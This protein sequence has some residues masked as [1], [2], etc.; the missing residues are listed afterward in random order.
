[1]VFSVPG[2][3]WKDLEA[4]E[5]ANLRALLDESA[6]ANVATRVTS[7][8]SE[9]GEAY[10]TLGTGTRA[11]AP[12]EVAG[13]SF[14]AD[15]LFGPTTAGEEWVRQHGRSTDAEVVSL[16]WTLIEDANEGAEF[17]G[18]IGALGD[19]LDARGRGPRG[20]R[21]RRRRRPAGARGAH[22]P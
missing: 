17:G 21:E 11:V 10:L 19:A 18:T 5:L 15:E 7:V 2:L 12:R 20:G 8:V 4:P 14:Q 16:G 22:P 13:M 6:I 9:P 3:T 1:M